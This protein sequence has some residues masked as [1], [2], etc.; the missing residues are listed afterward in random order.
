ML[1]HYTVPAGEA[2]S[3]LVIKNSV[4]VG[5]VGHAPDLEQAREY[6][7]AVSARYADANHN[8]W[9]YRISDGPQVYQR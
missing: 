8:A 7:A 5:T 6:V 3:E 2:Q 4:F 1:T 9:A